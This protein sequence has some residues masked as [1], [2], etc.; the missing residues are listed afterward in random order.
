M[1]SV[2]TLLILSLQFS[3][4]KLTDP[5]VTQRPPH[6]QLAHSPPN[7]PPPVKF[8]RTSVDVLNQ[9]DRYWT[10]EIVDEGRAQPHKK[11]RFRHR[12]GTEIL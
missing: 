2:F 11:Q 8:D 7:N 1:T 6:F 9:R 4:K 3:S 5:L 12:Y 10:L